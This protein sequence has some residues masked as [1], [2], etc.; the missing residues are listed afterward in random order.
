MPMISSPLRSTSSTHLLTIIGIL[1]WELA[2]IPV[3][4]P[5]GTPPVLFS[6]FT[7]LSKSTPNNGVVLDNVKVDIVLLLYKAAESVCLILIYRVPLGS[8]LSASWCMGPD[9]SRV[10]R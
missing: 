2:T 4:T 1:W 8:I 5:P 7:T 9:L 6:R 3:A 10:G